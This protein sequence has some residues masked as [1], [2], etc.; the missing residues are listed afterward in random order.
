MVESKYYS[1][2]VFKVSSHAEA[3]DYVE[4]NRDY[5]IE[6][7]DWFVRE[8]GIL[9]W[10]SRGKALSGTLENPKNYDKLKHLK[11]EAF[12]SIF[13]ENLAGFQ[14]RDFSGG[15]YYLEADKIDNDYL[16]WGFTE[17]PNQSLRIYFRQTL[18]YST[19][20][21]FADPFLWKRKGR[22]ANAQPIP[23]G[24][25]MQVYSLLFEYLHDRSAY[26]VYQDKLFSQVEALVGTPEGETHPTI[27]L[28]Q[29]YYFTQSKQRMLRRKEEIL[30]RLV[31]MDDDP[32]RRKEL[33]AEIRG[34]E[35]CI[36]V[37]EGSQPQTE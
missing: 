31:D 26:K 10:V 34:I 8:P 35:F 23:E 20:S 24:V 36:A 33:R 2:S 4:I 1:Y 13:N 7:E 32:A 16:L 21:I 6:T 15:E 22:R 9:L 3:R 27:I 25:F 12:L 14:K 19:F 18:E 29:D 17:K 11:E 5:Y 37:L 28:N 30:T